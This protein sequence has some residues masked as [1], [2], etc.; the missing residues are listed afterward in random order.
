MG[1]NTYY[2]M[3]ELRNS[4]GAK[5]KFFK[6]VGAMAPLAFIL[7]HPLDT[8]SFLKGN[9]FMEEKEKTIFC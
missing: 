6:F 3:Q 4:M 5:S 1:A 2:C 8:V 7:T 9:E